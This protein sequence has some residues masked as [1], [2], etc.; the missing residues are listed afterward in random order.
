MAEPSRMA[1]YWADKL[2]QA[3]RPPNSRCSTEQAQVMEEALKTARAEA[4]DMRLWSRK[5]LD[6]WRSAQPINPPVFDAFD[7]V[8]STLYSGRKKTYSVSG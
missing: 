2:A 7:A 5:M 8:R 3:A 6:A 1:Y 4:L